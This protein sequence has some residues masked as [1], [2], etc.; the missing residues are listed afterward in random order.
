MNL[1]TILSSK[2]LKIFAIFAV[3]SVQ[4]MAMKES[5]IE[6]QMKSKIDKTTNLLQNKELSFN[7]KTNQI[8]ETFDTVFDYASMSRIALGKKWKKLTL[9]QKNN[10]RKAFT[11][12]LKQSYMDKLNLYTDE[13]VSIEKIEKIKKN[14]IKLYTKL[15][16]QEEAYNIIYKF[17]KSK[18]TDNWLIYDVEMIGVSIMKT[19]RNQF[20]E[21][22]AS[23][24]FD[25][26]LV[27]L[28]TKTKQ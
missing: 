11:S 2:I 8:F 18:T 21:Y 22:L 23:N 26:L 7:D 10:F 3:L 17:H 19:Y 24:S 9:E 4:V 5:A 12:K 27:K 6:T 1:K 16:G 25:N 13:K 28:K 15:I 20:K 14:R